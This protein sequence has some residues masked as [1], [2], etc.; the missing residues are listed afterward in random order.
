MTSGSLYSRRILVWLIARL[1]HLPMRRVRSAKPTF[2]SLVD[3]TLIARLL[4][5]SLRVDRY[6]EDPAF[7]ERMLYGISISRGG[8]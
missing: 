8:A 2:R 7:D 5:D 6:Q 1:T 3:F 4:A